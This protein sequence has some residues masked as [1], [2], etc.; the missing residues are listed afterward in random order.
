MFDAYNV[1]GSSNV[2]ALRDLVNPASSMIFVGTGPAMPATMPTF[3]NA[4]TL[5]IS[6]QF[7][8]SS[9][10]SGS[11][12]YLHKAAGAEI[13]HVCTISSSLPGDGCLHATFNVQSGSTQVGS[14]GE[15]VGSNQLSSVIVAN[16]T[17]SREWSRILCGQRRIRRRR[18]PLIPG[19]LVC[20]LEQPPVRHPH[21]GHLDADGQL[22]WHAIDRKSCTDP[23]DV[24][25]LRPLDDA[26]RGEVGAQHLQ[27]SAFHG[28]REV[29]CPGVHQAALWDRSVIWIRLAR[30][31][32]TEDARLVA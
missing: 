19:H 18:C 28:S 17:T 5:D 25:E 32:E 21:Q 12:A 10:G 26:V 22:R 16:G 23:A 6:T 30:H 4:L 31:L 24:S 3:D 29:D 15:V 11:W 9:L 14:F 13:V 8:T 20:V 7:C 27:A 2:T 1:E